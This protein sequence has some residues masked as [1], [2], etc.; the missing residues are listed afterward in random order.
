MC[1]AALDRPLGPGFFRLLK[2][3]ESTREDHLE[4]DAP[5]RQ[6]TVTV[7][8]DG[9]VSRAGSALLAQVAD[10]T[11]LTRTLSCAVGESVL[12]F[13]TDETTPRER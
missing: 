1:G 11:G 4:G 9:L 2:L 3:V 8:A 6:M 12:Y 10:K 13:A 5:G 7:A